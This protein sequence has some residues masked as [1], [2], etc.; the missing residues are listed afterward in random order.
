MTQTTKG[1]QI[2]LKIHSRT[3]AHCRMPSG[4]AGRIIFLCT[5]LSFFL[6]SIVFAMSPMVSMENDG[7]SFRPFF[8]SASL[9]SFFLRSPIS[10]CSSCSCCSSKTE[11]TLPGSSSFSSFPMVSS[12]RPVSRRKQMIFI[13]FRSS[14]EYSRLPPS[15]S[16]LGIRIPFWS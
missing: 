16:A 10:S 6:F 5:A 1:H 4:M 8:S 12:D 7:V 15:V 9:S 11:I 3:D 13:F 2:P 14:P